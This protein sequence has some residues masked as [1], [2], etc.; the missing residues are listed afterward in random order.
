M[1]KY[2]IDRFF[3]VMYRRTQELGSGI[4]RVGSE[5]SWDDQVCGGVQS[6]QTECGEC[7]ERAQDREEDT[8]VFCLSF[9]FCIVLKY[10]HAR[11]RKTRKLLLSG[12]FFAIN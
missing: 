1:L 5:S 4:T 10:D 11:L 6:D 7:Q 9:K 12:S 8:G 3:L 2:N